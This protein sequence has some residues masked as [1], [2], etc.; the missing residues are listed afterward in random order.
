MYLYRE[1]WEDRPEI[2]R[3]IRS[4]VNDNSKAICNICNSQLCAQLSIIRKHLNKHDRN[5]ENNINLHPPVQLE[6]ENEAEDIQ[7]SHYKYQ[8]EWENNAFYS[9]WVRRVEGDSSK[10]HCTVC[11]KEIVASASSLWQHSKTYLHYRNLMIAAGNPTG[12]YLHKNPNFDP[13]VAERELQVAAYIVEENYSFKSGQKFTAFVK[14][15]TPESETN[16][17]M[18]MCPEKAQKLATKVIAP[19]QKQRLI[20]ILSVTKFS[21]LVDEMTDICTDKSLAIVVS[22]WD[23]ELKNTVYYL[24]DMISVY[25]KGEMR[26]IITGEHLFNLIK[27]SFEAEDITLNN[28]IAFSS[29]TA[30][31]MVGRNNSVVSR[32]KEA[33]PG[34]K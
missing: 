30:S 9:E 7:V 19:V 8:L 3:R 23:E 5:G 26:T 34:I 15:I 25:P 12:E 6:I 21:I 24:W 33:I 29:D 28:I 31:I 22:F 32:L 16:K 11:K 18:K 27:N 4:N 1:E 13:V 14:Y 10:A 2:R 20:E 17:K